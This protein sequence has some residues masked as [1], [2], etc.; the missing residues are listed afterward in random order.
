MHASTAPAVLELGLCGQLVS[1]LRQVS[2]WPDGA[3]AAVDAKVLDYAATLLGS[4][5]AE[6]CQHTCFLV[7][8][9]AE[10]TST[11]PAVLELGLCGQLVSL[12]ENFK[13]IEGAAYALGE[14]SQW[15]D[16]AQAALDAKVLDYPATLLGSPEHWTRRHAC[17]LVGR[18]AMHA[19]TAPAALELGL[20]K[21]LVS[22]D[23]NLE[24]IKGAAYALREI[25]QWPSGAQAAVD[26][27]VLDYAATLLGS[28]EHWTR[29]HACF[30]VGRLAM[31]ASTAPAAL[32]L[33]LCKQLVSLDENLEVIRGAA[34]ALRE[35]SQ[36]P[37]GAQAAVDAKVLDYPA[38]L[39]GSQERLIRRDTC[40]LVGC[41]ENLEV[42]KGAVC[43]FSRVSQW[44]DGAQATVDAKVLDY[45]A[46]LLG[47]L[48][49]EICQYTCFLMGRLAKHTSTAP[50]VLELGLCGQ[51]VSLLRDKNLEVIKGAAYA[52]C[53]VSQWPDGAQAAV[54]AK[55]L[56]HVTELLQSQEVWILRFTCELVGHLVSHEFTAPATLAATPWM[57]LLPCLQSN[58][59]FVRAKAAFALAKTSQQ[60]DG[61]VALADTGILDDLETLNQSSEDRIQAYTSR[62]RK[63]LAR[64]EEAKASQGVV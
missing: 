47:S 24:V 22:L 61:V 51:L 39:L 15:L 4:P 29:R 11:A 17:F 2:Q 30:L 36:W 6:I 50:A 44:L 9:L 31:H 42:I 58:T 49:A 12:D 25:S 52:L 18:L 37:N 3:Q 54:D 41:D 28:Q 38:T 5:E 55:V 57:W 13:V 16:G 10:H 46:T 32:E 59:D 7:G 1:L 19:S 62:I 60:P 45:M 14:I 40:F 20:C 56:D 34:Y 63:N 23:E 48:N 35:I 33:G 8:R 26:A 43:A 53:K 64:Y 21:Q 27:K